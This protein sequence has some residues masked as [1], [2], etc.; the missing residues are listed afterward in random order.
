MASCGVT[1]AGIGDTSGV[2]MS[3]ASAVMKVGVAS[4]VGASA[5]SPCVGVGG[6]P[7][8]A[9]TVLNVA[10]S[11]G[12]SVR[13]AV[14]SGR[15]VLL[16]VKVSG[17]LVGVSLGVCV[18][19]GVDVGSG[20]GL[21]VVVGVKLDVAVGALV[22]VA[23]G[24][25]VSVKLGVMVSVSVGT[26]GSGVGVGGSVS[27]GGMVAVALGCGVGVAVL[28][29]V[30][31]DVAVGALVKG[32]VGVWVGVLVD[33]NVGV[34][35]EVA[36]GSLVRVTVT[37]SVSLGSTKKVAVSEGV[38]LG[39]LLATCATIVGAGVLDTSGV[40]LGVRVGAIVG[41]TSGTDKLQ[42]ASSNASRI[43]LRR[44]I[45]I[46]H[47]PSAKDDYRHTVNDARWTYSL[48]LCNGLES[49]TSALVI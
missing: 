33:V 28:V 15:G 17:G 44:I 21:S 45:I 41:V 35:L 30:K 8:G 32:C 37:V 48:R 49:A 38:L 9:M 40:G 42:A 14:G 29:G 6:T 43:T 13:V 27:L 3:G 46:P 26:K 2:S 23:V 47:A 12:D 19:N 10:S 22:N 7:T 18:G 34:K 4:S 11:S 24:V 16:G 31:L 39:V 25:S 36:V 20:V 1:C 5:T